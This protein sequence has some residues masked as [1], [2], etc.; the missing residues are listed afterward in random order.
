[1]GEIIVKDG[2]TVVIKAGMVSVTVPLAVVIEHPK[3][4]SK[5]VWDRDIS[6]ELATNDNCPSSLKN[7]WWQRRLDQITGLTFHHT[8][9]NSP[10]ATAEHYVNKGG[11]RPSIPYTIWVSETGEILLCNALTDGCWHDHQ[12]HSNKNLSVGLAGQLH[13]HRPSEAQLVAAARVAVWATNHSDMNVTLT[14]VR[15]HRDLYP[16]IC[17]GWAS[18]KSGR[19]KPQLYNRIEA[20]LGR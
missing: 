19:W 2:D 9:S 1:M 11:G 5:N 3:P 6:G 16:T 15:G 7:G 13:I 17:P 20:M 18:V 8:L 12:G 14:T 10:H 4:E